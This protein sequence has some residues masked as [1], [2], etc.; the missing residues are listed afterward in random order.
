[1]SSR[2]FTYSLS[3]HYYLSIFQFIC[4]VILKFIPASL[5]PYKILKL[6]IQCIFFAC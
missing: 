4:Y 6:C 1:M 3:S 2:K 5:V